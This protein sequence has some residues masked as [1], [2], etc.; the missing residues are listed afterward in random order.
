MEKLYGVTSG[1]WYY[2]VE[3]C[4]E[5]DVKIGWATTAA[6]PDHELGDDDGSWAYNG[7]LEERSHGGGYDMFGKKW[8]VGD[9]IGV[10]LDA[11]EHTISESRCKTFKRR[12]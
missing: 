12:L 9:I 11:N 7:H 3:I 8:S 2:E 6:L 10:F 5:G 4:T 1:K